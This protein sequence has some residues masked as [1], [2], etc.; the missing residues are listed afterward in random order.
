MPRRVRD[1]ASSWVTEGASR[2]A[3]RGRRPGNP[4]LNVER[5]GILAVEL[6][7]EETTVGLAGLDAHFFAKRRFTTGNDPEQF[8]REPAQVSQELR[9]AHPRIACEGVGVSLPGRVDSDGRFI[10]A[11]NLAWPPV[12]IRQMIETAARLS[13]H[14]LRR[15]SRRRRFAYLNCWSSSRAC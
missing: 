11:P 8:V 12:P 6:R 14:E 13:S 7:P 3:E 2:Q 10:F 15:A 5:A 1:P 9:R 4:H